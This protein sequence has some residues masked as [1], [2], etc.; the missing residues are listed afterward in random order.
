MA[1]KFL[2]GDHVF[3]RPMEVEDLEVSYSSLW[4]TEGRRLTG[5]Q[6]TFTKAGIQKWFERISL[7]SGRIDLVIGMQEDDQLIGDIG[8]LEIDYRNRSAV[9]RIA[10]W[11]NENFGR[12]LGT[13][14]MYLLLEHGFE[15]LNL[16]RIG[17]DVFAYNQRAIRSY[18]K[19]G[20]QQEGII[21]DALFYDGEYHDSILMGM[22]ED[23]FRSRREKARHGRDNK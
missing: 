6:E 9:V 14:A 19:I 5:T 22:M 1:V 4:N 8:M 21:R 12:G 13:E 11:E 20:F 23:E 2:E 10:L 7:D 16:H 15:V 17:L 18:E 3:L